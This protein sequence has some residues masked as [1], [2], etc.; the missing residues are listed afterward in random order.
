MCDP[1]SIAGA[2]LTAGSVAAN[3]AAASSVASA[4]GKAMDAE[5]QRQ[6]G[7]RAQASQINDKSRQLYDG[8]GGQQDG[9]AKALGDYYTGANG[10]APAAAGA[11]S[12]APTETMPGSGSALVVQEQAKQG[13]KAQAYSDQQGDALGN[14]RS[15][16]DVMGTLGRASARNS[17]QVGQIG[18]FAQGSAGVLPYELEAANQKGNGM[19][20]FGDLL[21]GAGSL[22]TTYGLSRNVRLDPNEPVLPAPGSPRTTGT[23]DDLG[24]ELPALPP[25]SRLGSLGDL[26]KIY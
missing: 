19:K 22:A 10:N 7:F 16:G 5:R 8:F 9:R 25:Q 23:I 11:G 14:L 2:A 3:S 17:Q 24:R 21:K 1:V 4:R 20:M 26:F 15:F 6:A 12:T 18:N 13:G